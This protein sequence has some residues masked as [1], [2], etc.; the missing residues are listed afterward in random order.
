[1]VTDVTSASQFL[2]LC[3]RQSCASHKLAAAGSVNNGAHAPGQGSHLPLP[4]PLQAHMP[5]AA[6]SI[7]NGAHAH[8][9]TATP[10]R[11]CPC[12]CRSRSTT[13]KSTMGPRL[14]WLSSTSTKLSGWA[15]SGGVLCSLRD[16]KYGEQKDVASS[17]AV[18]KARARLWQ[19][20]HGNAAPLLVEWQSFFGSK[21]Q[22]GQAKR[23]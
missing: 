15:G 13:Q 10:L 3:V 14:G 9:H 8:S 19:W 1:M 6:R 11:T 23:M 21:W 12:P 7:H 16:G 4:L 20:L 17:Q 22:C 5:A 18:M 2:A